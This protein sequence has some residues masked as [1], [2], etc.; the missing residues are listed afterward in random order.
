MASSVLRSMGW[1]DRPGGARW[2][3]RSPSRNWLR[4][5]E[6]G[7]LETWCTCSVLHRARAL[8]ACRSKRS[9]TSWSSTAS[10]LPSELSATLSSLWADLEVDLVLECTGLFTER[11]DAEKDTRAGASWWCCPGRP[12]ARRADDR[13]RR[14][15][16]RRPTSRS[17]PAP[18]APPT[19]SPRWWRS[20]TDTS[21]SR[22]PADD[23]ARLHRDPGPGRQPRRR[24]GPR[25]AA[26]LPPRTSSPPAPARPRPPPRRC[27]P[28]RVASTVSRSGGR[29]VHL[30]VVFVV[31]RTPRSTR[32]TTCCQRRRPTG[33]RECSASPRIR[34]ADIVKDPQGL[35]RPAGPDPGGWGQP[36][37][38]DELVRQR[39]GSPARW[40]RSRCNSS[41][42]TP[43]PGSERE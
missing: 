2:R 41:A 28:C 4:R 17:S 25:F 10:R 16:P 8:R 15:P 36:G 21:A 42:S 19:T 11:E 14:Q 32:S 3:W 31:A 38:G 39:G 40:S 24:Q 34:C 27:R 9:T 29:R 7:S 13:P 23:R 43:P 1:P 6:I 22:R 12:R 18:A 37:Q 35:H 30:D 26:A 5:N 33:T 20:R